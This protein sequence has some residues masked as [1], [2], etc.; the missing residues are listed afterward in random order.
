MINYLIMSIS[1]RGSF[2]DIQYIAYP[3]E[4]D[5][6]CNA[7]GSPIKILYPSEG[8]VHTDFQ[9]KIKEIIELMGTSIHRAQIIKE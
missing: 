2:V 5:R 7:C 4:F 3:K 6:K 8:H 9:G 1:K